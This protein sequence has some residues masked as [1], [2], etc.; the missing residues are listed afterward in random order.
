MN[1][2]PVIVLR[3]LSKSRPFSSQRCLSHLHLVPCL[4]QRPRQVVPPVR[5][6]GDHPQRVLLAGAAQHDRRRRIGKRRPIRLPDAIIL[7][8]KIRR[9][10]RPQRPDDLHALLQHL[11]S[12]AERREVV[13]VGRVLRLVP[14]RA[15]PEDEPAGGQVLKARPHLRQH[16]RVPERVAH[17][18]RAQVDAGVPCRDPGQQRPALDPELVR[19]VEVVRHP[20]R[21]EALRGHVECAV[22]V[23]KELAR[24][25]DLHVAGP[26][27]RVIPELHSSLGHHHFTFLRKRTWQR[28][29]GR[30]VCA[31]TR[32]VGCRAPARP[33]EGAGHPRRAAGPRRRAG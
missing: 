24:P 23:G 4:V 31:L 1:T 14:A 5:L 27:R 13:A 22:E 6:P 15:V 19:V 25:Y 7:A 12:R 18:D 17:H 28:G 16:R 3:R 10:L 29:A 26:G 9:R 33:R 8:R 21:P 11:Q 32:L 30:Q 20:D 2:R